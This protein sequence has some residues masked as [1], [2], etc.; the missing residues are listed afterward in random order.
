LRHGP[1]LFAT[2]S[3]TR[4]ASDTTHVYRVHALTAFLSFELY[5]VVLLNLATIE[6]R[7][8]YEELLAGGVV[9][10]KAKSFGLIEKFYCSGFHDLGKK[11]K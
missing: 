11:K 8:V 3:S 7:D 4:L 1:S 6:T 10:N 5:P 9:G 2:K